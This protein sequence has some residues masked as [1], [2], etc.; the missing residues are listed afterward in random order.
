MNQFIFLVK[1]QSRVIWIHVTKLNTFL[2]QMFLPTKTCSKLMEKIW[3]AYLL[4]PYQII[5]IYEFANVEIALGSVLRCVTPMSVLW[6]EQPTSY[7]SCSGHTH[8]TFQRWGLTKCILWLMQ[9]DRWVVNF[10]LLLMLVASVLKFTCLELH[11]IISDYAVLL[12]DWNK[13]CNGKSN[14]ATPLTVVT[15]R[16]VE[17]GCFLLLPCGFCLTSLLSMTPPLCLCV[18]VLY[19]GRPKI[20]ESD[21][22]IHFTGEVY[23]FFKHSRGNV[24]TAEPRLSLPT[25]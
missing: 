3:N 12:F 24:H 7:Y 22:N 13:V 6:F 5:Q 8:T 20:Y 9:Q 25:V 19:A 10:P 1:I 14:I 23:L 21:R 2:S 17:H 16:I 11:R 18:C 15:R 4:L